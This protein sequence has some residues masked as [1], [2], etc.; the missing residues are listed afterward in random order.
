M[1]RFEDYGDYDAL[2][3]AELVRRGELSAGELLDEALRRVEEWNPRLG[4]VV[5]VMEERARATLAGPPPAG[6]FAGVPYLIKDLLAAYEGEPMSWGSRF[7]ADYRPRRDSEVVAR[8]RRAGLVIFGKTATPELGLLPVTESELFGATRN[9]WDPG[10]TP[11]GSSG[12]SAAAVAARMVPMASGGD[13]GGSIRIPASCCGVFG[14]KPSRGRVPTGPDAGQIWHGCVAEHVLTRTVRDSAA[15]LDAIAGRDAGA[16][17]FAPEPEVAFL[18]QIERPPGALR[19]AFTTRPLLGDR[20]DPECVR[21]VEGA[22]RLLEGLGHRVEEG[23]PEVDADAFRR[24][25]MR[26]IC[27]EVRADIV[28]GEGL[29][30]RRA[31]RADFEL[32]TWVSGLLGGRIA[33]PELSLAL[34]TMERQGRAIGRFF[35]DYDV[36]VTPTLAEPPV[37]VGSLGLGA[38]ER[39]LLEPLA[40]LG[41]GRVLHALG[42]ID[43]AAA[44]AFRFTPFTPLF[45]ASGQP[46]MSMPLHRSPAGLP[47]GVHFV[48]RPAED[49][50]LLRLARQL[51]EACPWIDRVPAGVDGGAAA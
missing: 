2:A 45:N 28:E 29:V 25:F 7:F 10:R 47:I 9:P 1:A 22:A 34:R 14:L 43:K 40:R 24:A 26:M 32:A 4:A 18:K 39:A 3:L 15:M 30:G 37:A 42:A 33:G 44:D 23:A 41:A 13:G 19:V 17:Y 50:S 46:A 11:G 31:R 27:V 20:V 38:G 35:E 36:L 48:G 8:S 49:G 5:R 12:G 21:A 16:P 51:E 6:P